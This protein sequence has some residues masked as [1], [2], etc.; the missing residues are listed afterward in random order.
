MKKNAT[1][2]KDRYVRSWLE[3]ICEMKTNCDE[4][5]RSE[6]EF[7]E[8]ILNEYLT[9]LNSKCGCLCSCK[10]CTR[11]LVSPEYYSKYRSTPIHNLLGELIYEPMEPDSSCEN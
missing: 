5:T 10:I 1:E 2:I 9:F 3:R 7:R 11:K 4:K 6:L 8:N